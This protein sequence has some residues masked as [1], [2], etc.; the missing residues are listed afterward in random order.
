M[1][2]FANVQGPQADFTQGPDLYHRCLDWKE[3]CELLLNRPLAGKSDAV[4]SNYILIWAGK[5][6]RTHIKSLNLTEAQRSN[7]TNLLDKLV[8]W[9]K[10]RSNELA[11]AA[12][13]RE[14]Q[15]G[16]MSLAE[17]IDKATVMVDQCG[18]PEQARDRLLRDAIVIGLK[19]R[20][21]YFKCIEKGSSLT[22]QEAIQIAESSEAT[23]NQV[24][25]MRPE[26][27]ATKEVH[28]L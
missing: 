3:E 1:A 21:A 2:E 17:Y 11:A 19:S 9:T 20:H 27:S 18:Y 25:Y 10:P 24:S 7:P 6:G 5:K 26:F 16:N 15:Q 14:L 4:K 8:D 12:K 22:L 13:L 23:E 28:K